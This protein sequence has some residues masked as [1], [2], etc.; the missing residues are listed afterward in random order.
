MNIYNEILPVKNMGLSLLGL[1][2]TLKLH[3]V[4]LQRT[5]CTLS[6]AVPE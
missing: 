5:V 3:Y 6:I 4:D 2:R 1:I